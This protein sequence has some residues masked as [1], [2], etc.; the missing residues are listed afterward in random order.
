VVI[1]TESVAAA[2]QLIRGVF[3]SRTAASTADGLT[4]ALENVL[5]HGKQAWPLA[6]IR[7][8]AD[9]LLEVESGR[10]FS[11]RHE[12]RW[13][14]L[15]GFCLR[16]GFGAAV[17]PWRVLEA[18]KVYAQGL[19]FDKETQC[20]VEWLILWQRVSAG[21][22]A[23]QQQE[24]ANRM[25]GL[26]GLGKRKAGRLNPQMLRD[27]W[28]LLAGLERLDRS[29]RARL[30]DELLARLVR[31]PQNGAFASAIGRF[32]ARMPL[33]GPLSSVVAADVA[34]RWLEILLGLKSF[35]GDAIAAVVQ[36]GARTDDPVRDISDD[37]RGRAVARLTQLGVPEDV[38]RS[39]REHVPV[40]RISGGRMLGESLPEGLRLD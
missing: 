10:R 33:Y 14:N 21:F 8:L 37:G 29:Q 18:R 27:A 39:L 19:A 7:R 32:G 5:G 2:E 28:R 22:N 30:G 6:I 25:I 16:P 9:V 13:L 34:E 17:D 4:G 26:L 36:I 24:L 1:D 31:E 38:L 23:A 40:D 11:A 35:S 12:A 15:A 3:A 20:Q